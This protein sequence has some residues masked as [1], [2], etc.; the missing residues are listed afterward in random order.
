MNHLRL[1]KIDTKIVTQM[2]SIKSIVMINVKAPRTSILR[3]I[4]TDNGAHLIDILTDNFIF[5][6]T[7]FQHDNSWRNTNGENAMHC[8]FR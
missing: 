2:I 5:L 3:F 6:Q 1:T 4:G 7:R 8:N